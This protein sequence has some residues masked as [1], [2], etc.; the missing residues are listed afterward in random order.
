MSSTSSATITAVPVSEWS[1][2]LPAWATTSDG[3]LSELQTPDSLTAG[4]DSSQ[5]LPTPSAWVQDEVDLDKYLARRAREK[6]KGRNGNGFG[7]PLDMAIRLLPTPT[8]QDGTS[9]GRS[10][11]DLESGL[12][13]DSR[14][15]QNLKLREAVKLLPTTPTGAST[16]EQ[17]A[18]GS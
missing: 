11:A 16:P 3:V 5:L 2:K 14:G 8:T 9:D 18:G 7:L 6:A 10:K 1:G 17:S 13:K 4:R 15:R 12:T